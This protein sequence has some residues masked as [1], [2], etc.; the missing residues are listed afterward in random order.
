MQS[1][2]PFERL[3]CLIQV[4]FAK[5]SQN[6]EFVGLYLISIIVV[7]KVILNMG[8]PCFSRYFSTPIYLYLM[9]IIETYGRLNPL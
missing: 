5:E 4:L 3:I 2:Y 8:R 6:L 7:K 1:D 9:N